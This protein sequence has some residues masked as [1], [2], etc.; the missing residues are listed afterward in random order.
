M[1]E[2]LPAWQA[3]WVR[4]C[5][6]SQET[7]RFDCIRLVLHHIPRSAYGFGCGGPGC[8]GSMSV[9]ERDHHGSI[10]RSDHLQ[11]ELQ[12]KEGAAIT[13]SCNL[14]GEAT[15]TEVPPMANTHLHADLRQCASR[16]TDCMINQTAV[17]WRRLR[18]SGGP[19]IGCRLRYA[20]RTF[21]GIWCEV[22]ENRQQT[23]Q[24]ARG[25]S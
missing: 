20:F 5:Q 8:K 23:R 16:G 7:F 12:E 9:T 22:P 1:C 13:L 24:P 19:K 14:D 3:C 21:W 18:C 25:S 2:D 4:Q 10:L 11:S 6:Q 15:Q 17:S